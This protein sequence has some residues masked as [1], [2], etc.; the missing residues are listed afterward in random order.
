MDKITTSNIDTVSVCTYTYNDKNLLLGLLQNIDTWTIQPDEIIII[1]DGS[2][3]PLTLDVTKQNIN[4]VRID[5]NMGLCNAK[6]IGPNISTSKYIFSIDCDT[7]VNRDWLEKCLPHAAKPNVGIVGGVLTQN[8]GNDIVSKYLMHFGD[9]HNINID[10]FVDFIPGNA[11]LMRFDVWKHIGGL[12][13]HTRKICEDRFLC[14]KMK[15]FGFKLYVEKLATAFQVR[16]LSRI[17]MVKRFFNWNYIALINNLPSEQEFPDYFY[18]EF[19]LL[20]IKY[21]VHAI[22]LN[23]PAFVYLNFLDMVYTVSRLLTYSVS[24]IGYSIE[25]ERSWIYAIASYLAP[26]PSVQRLL[27]ED[28]LQD[29]LHPDDF[30]AVFNIDS[31]WD[32]SFN[33]LQSLANKGGVW[34]R[35]EKEGVSRIRQEDATIKH[36]FSFHL[37]YEPD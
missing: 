32:R 22:E 29:R 8:A 31:C 36:D 24:N 27:I 17:A 37:E 18:F 7:R 30:R 16:R 13:G 33:L 2:D 4:I 28:A 1:D 6:N 26:Y 14:I 23:E 34:D 21:Y 3:V 20:F 5:S 19:V 10:G 15:A 11:R 25:I 12:T 35:L 9:N